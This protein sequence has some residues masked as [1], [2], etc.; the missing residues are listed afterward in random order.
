MLRIHPLSRVLII[1][2]PLSESGE[3]QARALGRSDI[4]A[5]E[6]F[7]RKYT[8]DLGRA[9]RTTV[10]ILGEER[11]LE[12]HEVRLEPLLRELAKGVR[13][14]LPKSMTYEEAQV[15][16][17]KEHGPTEPFPPLETEEDAMARV[18]KWLFQVVRDAIQEAR[19][20]CSALSSDEGAKRP[21]Q[22]FSVFA[23]S[24][25]GTLRATIARLVRD[26]LPASIDLT[27]VGRDGA[28]KGHMIVP[29]TSVTIVDIIP[30]NVED[31]IWDLERES[32]IPTNP[33][34][35]WKAKLKTLIHTKH[36]Q[37]V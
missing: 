27:P 28:K 29:N 26:Q 2:K 6:T 17:R 22:V 3:K 33:S 11:S 32:Q 18:Y 15:A 7:W 30:D 23:V 5:K 19:L 35:L 16:F 24:H 14:G 1:V 21:Q 20:E 8:S 36:Y 37:D 4:L 31:E 10:L 34:F 13:E 9:R 12:E 25:S